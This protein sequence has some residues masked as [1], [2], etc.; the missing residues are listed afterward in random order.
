[1][2]GNHMECII[3]TLVGEEKE[4]ECPRTDCVEEGDPYFSITNF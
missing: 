4:G 1:M 2:C 3:G